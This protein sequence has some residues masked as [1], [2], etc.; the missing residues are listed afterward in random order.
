AVLKFGG[1]EV[2]L[3]SEL[4]LENTWYTSTSTS[5]ISSRGVC[6]GIS[7]KIVACV[8]TVT[9]CRTKS[10]A[11]SVS[12]LPGLGRRDSAPRRSLGSPVEKKNGVAQRG[13]TRHA[14]NA[15]ATATKLPR[16]TTIFLGVFNP[17]KKFLNLYIF[18]SFLLGE[19]TVCR[20]GSF[21]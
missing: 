12:I 9:S 11:V 17:F 14:I 18:P 19:L 1:P 16:E 8:R 20:H 21:D 15:N 5:R 2:R 10:S 6:A 13:V 3:T 7:P 4:S